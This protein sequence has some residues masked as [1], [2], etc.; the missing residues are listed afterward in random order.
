MKKT[1]IFIAILIIAVA[2]SGYSLLSK[3]QLAYVESSKLI[4]GFSE[5]A[6]VRHQF[7]KEKAEWETNIKALEDSLKIAMERM[8]KEYDRAS[9]KEKEELQ[10]Q[11]EKRNAN[12][13]QYKQIVYQKSMQREQELLQPVIEK[14]NSF[15]AIWGKKNGYD[16]ILGT[17]KGGNIVHAN[18]DFNV[19]EKALRALNEHYKN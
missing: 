7:E 10:S 14:I 13:S 4:D 5:T 18:T 1:I 8:K 9:A 16:L 6:K 3:P 11:F 2:L 12:L 15:M 19:T 17:M